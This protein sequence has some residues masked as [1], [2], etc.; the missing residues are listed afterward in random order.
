VHKLGHFTGNPASAKNAW[1]SVVVMVGRVWLTAAAMASKERAPTR[2]K[3]CLV[4]AKLAQ[5][6]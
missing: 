1:A 5:S 6:G 3:A 4:S 2:R